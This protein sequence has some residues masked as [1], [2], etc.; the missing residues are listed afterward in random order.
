MGIGPLRT[1]R[2]PVP[3]EGT[4]ATRAGTL[5]VTDT[6]CVAALPARFRRRGQESGVVHRV[7]HMRVQA[8]PARV[9]GDR[10]DALRVARDRHEVVQVRPAREP[11]ASSPR[12]AVTEARPAPAAC[13]SFHLAGVCAPVAGKRS[14]NTPS[15]GTKGTPSDEV[16]EAAEDQICRHFDASRRYP[17]GNVIGRER[18]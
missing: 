14:S 3:I 5:R 2:S 17:P 4:L 12:I 10:R 6:G 9:V 16:L 15:P 1:A 18:R 13:S 11:S 8:L 7:N